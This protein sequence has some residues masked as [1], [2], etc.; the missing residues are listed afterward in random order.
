MDVKVYFVIVTYNSSRYICKAVDSIHRC[1]PKAEIVVVDNASQDD[2]LVQLT[3][4]PDISVL[5]QAQNLGFG[6]ANNK[7]ISFALQNGADFIY[8]LNH[9]AFLVEPITHTLINLLNAHP[10]IGVISPFQFHPDNIHLESNFARFMFQQGILNRYFGE[11]RTEA[12]S[13]YYLVDFV[14]A[15]SWF[16]PAAVF[17]KLGGFDPIFFHYGE[18]NNFLQRLKYHHFKVA[19]V[20]QLSI[21]HETNPIKSGYKKN[22]NSY[23]LNRLRSLK[24]SKYTDINLPS[25]H[26]E[27]LRDINRE[28]IGILKNFLTL[29]WSYIPGRLKHLLFLGSVWPSIVTSREVAK[30]GQGCYLRIP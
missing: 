20:P 24:L 4:Y 30:M 23:H 1:E 6:K 8:L 11:L 13:E 9:D 15:A 7:G 27:Y 12:L 26:C 16:I 28:V 18:D 2:T 19:V 29:R 3:R 14:Q 21:T 25:V 5:P 17:R 10:E 22:Y